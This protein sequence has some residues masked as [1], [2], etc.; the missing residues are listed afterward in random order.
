MSREEREANYK[1]VRDRIFGDMVETSAMEPSGTGETSA[2]MSRSSSASGKKKG[3]RQR[4]PKDD[5]FEARSQFKPNTWYPTLTFTNQQQLPAEAIPSQTNFQQGQYPI[6]PG[7][8]AYSMNYGSNAAHAYGPQ[9]LGPTTAF[10]NGSTY[11]V[12][13]TIPQYD[14]R[15]GWSGHQSP[16]STVY[17]NYGT[18][19]HELQGSSPQPAAMPSPVLNQYGQQIATQMPNAQPTWVPQPYQTPYP[20]AVPYPQN[21][22]MAWS[23][24]PGQMNVGA[25]SSFGQFPSQANNTAQCSAPQFP[26][27]AGLQ[28]SSF[29]PQTRSFIPSSGTRSAPNFLPSKSLPFAQ[30]QS[31]APIRYGPALDASSSPS[32]QPPNFS[33]SPHIASS[34]NQ[35]S[36]HPHSSGAAA[37]SPSQEDSLR[38]KWGTPSH[39]PKKP[40]PSEVPSV[41]DVEK[42]ASLPSQ[43]SFPSIVPPGPKSSGPLVVSGGSGLP[44]MN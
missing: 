15:E 6:T 21:T 44:M 38:K 12:R 9:S 28:G 41:Y 24:V 11:G 4:V 22:P 5:S 18:N 36:S 23:S 42:T 39:L 13:P 20:Q 17:Y 19:S 1:S 37:A 14:Y 2:S 3:H 16:Q 10:Q 30:P 27:P 40:P 25:P 33:S 43:K 8:S 35:S 31:N 26:H 32:R 34:R 29:N 7:S